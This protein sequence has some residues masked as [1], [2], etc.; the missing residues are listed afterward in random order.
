MRVNSDDC[1]DVRF[2][3][4]HDRAWI[5]VKDVFLYSQ[6]PPVVVKNK[7]RGNIEAIRDEVD[8]YIKHIT[9]KF[10]KFEHSPYKTALDPR[11][12][13]EQIKI[14]YPK[15]GIKTRRCGGDVLALK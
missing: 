11:K 3:G 5:P 4:A 9:D 12:E 15:V 7:K 10:G 13:E 14:L 6:E 8:R 1:V 2:F